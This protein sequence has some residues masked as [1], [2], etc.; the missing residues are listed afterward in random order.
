MCREISKGAAQRTKEFP[1]GPVIF[2]L[3]ELLASYLVK[4]FGCW[5]F[6]V[7]RYFTVW[8]PFLLLQRSPSC[9]LNATEN[10]SGGPSPELG[11]HS[12]KAKHMWEPFQLCSSS[13]QVRLWSPLCSISLNM[14]WL[15]GKNQA[16]GLW[17]PE[18]IKMVTATHR[19]ER[20]RGSIFSIRFMFLYFATISHL[21][22]SNQHWNKSCREPGTLSS[23]KSEDEKKSAS[24]LHSPPSAVSEKADRRSWGDRMGGSCKRCWEIRGFTMECGTAAKLRGIG[25][26][27]QL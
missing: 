8:N 22:C 21:W 16:S 17:N 1:V 24:F 6:L 2:I 9:Q 14:A 20:S 4:M 12:V 19:E 7:F 11:A 27:K 5:I 25:S 23:Q 10:S 13:L 3:S 18:T 15:R 26:G